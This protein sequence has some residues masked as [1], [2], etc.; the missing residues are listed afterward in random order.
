MTYTTKSKGRLTTPKKSRKRR[1]SRRRMSVKKSRKRR[2]SR[3]RM[4]VKKLIQQIPT[5]SDMRRPLSK[6]N[7]PLTI[8]TDDGCGACQKLKELLSKK[9]IKF[10]S[11]LRKD[12][13][14]EVQELTNGYKYIPVIIDRNKKFIG[15]FRDIQKI[16]E[17]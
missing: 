16:L 12:H 9:G 8:Y 3:R 11:Y 5:L 2:Q 14:E 1:Q 17:E 10:N 6:V 4:S 15:G 13:E 7:D